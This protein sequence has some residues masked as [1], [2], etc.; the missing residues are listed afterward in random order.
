M[1]QANHPW[2][3]ECLENEDFEA[4]LVVTN[5]GLPAWELT[6]VMRAFQTYLWSSAPGADKV[7]FAH[8]STGVIISYDG[9]VVAIECGHGSLTEAMPDLISVLYSLGWRS[10]AV[11]APADH[12]QAVMD[13]IARCIS[14]NLDLEI[15]AGERPGEVPLNELPEARVIAE[16][17]RAL[18]KVSEVDDGVLTETFR[19]LTTTVPIML[20]DV[21]PQPA[22]AED[23]VVVVAP[24]ILKLHPTTAVVEDRGASIPFELAS[25]GDVV[26]ASG[27]GTTGYDLQH[28]S[29]V[30]GFEQVTRETPPSLSV[31]SQ[32]SQTG[33]TESDN[34]AVVRHFAAPT[35]LEVAPTKAAITTPDNG[36]A[37]GDFD[38][39]VVGKATFYFPV[40]ASCTHPDLQSVGDG[41]VIH[42]YPGQSAP[43]WRWNLLDEIDAD[44]PSSADMLATMVFDD[45]ELAPQL[46]QL[47]RGGR[48]QDLPGQVSRAN[49]LFGSDGHFLSLPPVALPEDKAYSEFSVREILINQL[50]NHYVLHVDT[51]DGPFAV[52]VMKGL[53]AIAESYRHSV[54]LASQILQTT[55]ADGDQAEV[56]SPAAHVET[57]TLQTTISQQVATLL[58]TLQAAGIKLPAAGS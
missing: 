17:T 33:A 36:D 24:S 42:L 21:E 44:Y 58:E 30:Q 32:T 10:M 3:D 41:K 38:A 57:G 45:Q 11:F 53:R 51:M 28:G 6:Q 56:P 49:A 7:S 43:D 23:A 52:W 34:A 47:A 29:H 9:N 4:V 46:L 18:L 13:D 26:V 19:S 16:H 12:L 39:V 35:T 8:D 15:T 1:S 27:D 31:V 5:K 50:P 48:Y 20:D 55:T 2:I 25:N 40:G 22:A 37:T 54:R 14:A